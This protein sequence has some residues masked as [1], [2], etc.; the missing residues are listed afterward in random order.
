MS[1]SFLHILILSLFAAAGIAQTPVSSRN[2]AVDEGLPASHIL[3]ITQDSLNYM[4]FETSKGSVRFNG[5]DFETDS[6]QGFEAM[7]TIPLPEALAELGQQNVITS[8]FKDHQGS[9]WVGTEENGV[10]YYPNSEGRNESFKVH[11]EFIGLNN[12]KF[13]HPEASVTI[14][15]EFETLSIG[16]VAIDYRA[17]GKQLYRYKIDG[18]HEEWVETNDKK[19]QFTAL[20]DGGIYIFNV[21]VQQKNGSWGESSSLEL[22]FLTPFYKTWWFLT[23]IV[24]S[25]LVLFWV[26]IRY[27]Y[28]RRLKFQEMRT[29]ILQLES[30]ALQSQMNPHFVFNSLNSIQGFISSGDSFKSEVYLSK[31]SALL[32]KTLENSRADRISLSREIDHLEN[33]LELEKVRFHDKLNYHIEVAEEIESDL[34]MVPP[35]LIQPFVENAIVHGLAPKEEGGTVTIDFILN[36]ENSLV[37]K[38]VDDGVGRSPEAQKAH[39][40]LGT[41]IVSKRLE[42][43]SGD[44]LKRVQYLD[45]KDNNDKATGTQV[46]IEIPV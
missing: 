14:P 7:V 38:I 46:T 45:L 25:G 44:T 6:L 32:R 4:Y 29:E 42:L 22:N 18:I 2:Y 41:S 1:R 24:V 36:G 30:K 40:S 28:K 33:Y 35:M 21:Q 11:F 27:Y 9:Y 10:Y 37:C 20:P 31:F 5:Y 13:D 26:L 43:I 15:Y 34:I 23:L 16:Y 8:V 12:Q 19:I 39:D 3:S 17:A